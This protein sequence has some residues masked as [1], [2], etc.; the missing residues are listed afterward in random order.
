MAKELNL[1]SLHQLDWTDFVLRKTFNKRYVD[2]WGREGVTEAC[3]L[4]PHFFANACDACNYEN[5]KAV[6]DHIDK[7]Y[8]FGGFCNPFN[9]RV[10]EKSQYISPYKDDA[11]L[12]PYMVCEFERYDIES[13]FKCYIYPHAITAIEDTATGE[14]MTARLD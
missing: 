6:A 12:S 13:S 4:I 5:L 11:P 3:G 1:N 10:D 2:Q 8:G 9:G 7:Q 14:Q